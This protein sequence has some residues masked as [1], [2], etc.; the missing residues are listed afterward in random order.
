MPRRRRR[1]RARAAAVIILILGLAGLGVSL[2]GVA[3]QVFPRQ[4]TAHQQR[5]ILDWEVSKRWRD[6]KAGQIFPALV[7]YPA[8]S[9]LGGSA[10]LLSAD[11]IGIASQASCPAAADTAVAAVLVRNGCQA[12]LRATYADRTDSYVVTVGVAAFPGSAA[13]SAAHR[14]LS[15]STQN[16][17]AVVGVRTVPFRGTRAAWFSNSRRQIS[18][19]TNAGTYVV[20]YTIGYADRRQQVA[21][22]SDSYAY[23]EMDSLGAGVAQAVVSVLAKPPPS[24]RCP[25]TPGC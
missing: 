14:E 1:G 11:R 17:R 3:A 10:L 20:F 5:Q 8:P 4:F 22:D 23:S 19:N 2:A 9:E 12:M 25:G 16:G 13:A 24:P 18:A 7:H 21:V 6:L 15:G